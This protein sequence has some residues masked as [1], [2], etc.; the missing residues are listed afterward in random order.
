[1]IRSS[2]QGRPWRFWLGAVW[3]ICLWR[4]GHWWWRG[5]DSVD[6]T[7]WH[8]G[9]TGWNLMRF[10]HAKIISLLFGGFFSTSEMPN[11]RWFGEIRI[12]WLRSK[13]GDCCSY[14]NLIQKGHPKIDEENIG[15]RSLSLFQLDFQC[16]TVF[17]GLLYSKWFCSIGC[18]DFLRRNDAVAISWLVHGW[19]DTCQEMLVGWTDVE[20]IL[21]EIRGGLNYVKQ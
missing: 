5:S 15:K 16:S 14:S 17:G 7:G 10:C 2:C 21:C 9:D 4:H 1:M 18:L 19:E 6:F 13:A 8:K 20:C 12:H 3:R 11:L